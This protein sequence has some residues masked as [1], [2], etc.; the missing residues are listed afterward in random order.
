[1]KWIKKKNKGLFAQGLL[2]EFEKRHDQLSVIEQ[3]SI[4]LEQVELF[5]Q[6]ADAQL[7]K[8]LKQLLEDASGE[9]GLTSNWKL[10]LDVVNLIVKWQMRVDKLIVADSS[11]RGQGKFGYTEA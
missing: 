5:L 9:L 10:I 3:R 6:A 7:Q 1:M 4:R 8:S 11:E 2:Q